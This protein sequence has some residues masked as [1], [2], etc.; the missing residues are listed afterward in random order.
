MGAIILLKES[1]GINSPLF[2][3]K[4]P[5]ILIIQDLRNFSKDPYILH[6]AGEVANLANERTA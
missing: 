2:C 1:F 4:F 5:Q 3:G 6:A